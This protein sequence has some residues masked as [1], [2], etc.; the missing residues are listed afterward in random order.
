MKRLPTLVTFRSAEAFR[1]DGIHFAY[2]KAGLHVGLL[3]ALCCMAAATRL[4]LSGV[5]N[6]LM[7]ALFG[8]GAASMC[9]ALYSARSMEFPRFPRLSLEELEAMRHDMGILPEVFK[10]THDNVLHGTPDE[11]R[12]IETADAVLSKIQKNAELSQSK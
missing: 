5:D 10:Q 4:A 1:D 12:A 8:L 2:R 7:W 6:G 11:F 9:I 3:L